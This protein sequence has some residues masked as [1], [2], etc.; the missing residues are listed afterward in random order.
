MMISDYCV[1]PIGHF[2][3]YLLIFPELCTVRTNNF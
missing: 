3:F 1:L 2:F